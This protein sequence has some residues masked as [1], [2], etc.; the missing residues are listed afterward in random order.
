MWVSSRSGNQQIW[1][2]TLMTYPMFFLMSQT[3]SILGT[4]IFTKRDIVRSQQKAASKT[5]D[6]A[7][8]KSSSEDTATLEVCGSRKGLQA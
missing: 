5:I 2:D 3:Y 1:D 7:T 4:R 8:R 6:A